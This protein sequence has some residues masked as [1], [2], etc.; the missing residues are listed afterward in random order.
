MPLS[1]I[2]DTHSCISRIN[3]GV[4]T[5]MAH[6]FEE[7]MLNAHDNIS[8]KSLQYSSLDFVANH[9]ALCTAL[10]IKWYKISEAVVLTIS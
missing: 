6:T 4:S 10:Q 3:C 5:A 2:I 7:V 8:T 1:C 9:V